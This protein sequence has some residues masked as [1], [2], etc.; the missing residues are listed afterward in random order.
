MGENTEEYRAVEN[1]NL[2]VGIIPRP[3]QLLEERIERM[4]AIG[5]K[6]ITI[7]FTN[8]W[9][10]KYNERYLLNQVE[11]LTKKT[12]YVVDHVYVPEHSKIG[13][14][15]IH[16]IFYVTNI[17][18]VTNLLKKLDQFGKITIKT[19]DDSPK[20]AKYCVKSMVPEKDKPPGLA[21]TGKEKTI[22]KKII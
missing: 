19:I 2:L 18:G 16:G 3:E 4:G 1:T 5:G 12:R 10:L 13:R 7:T 9:I 17:R 11:T 22:K 20:W 14:F 21:E 8:K 6:A 15:H